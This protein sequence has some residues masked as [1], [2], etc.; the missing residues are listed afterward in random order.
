MLCFFATLWQNSASEYVI[1]TFSIETIQF[2]NLHKQYIKNK[3]KLSNRKAFLFV[4]YFI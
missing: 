2:K 1:Q 4:S 3:K